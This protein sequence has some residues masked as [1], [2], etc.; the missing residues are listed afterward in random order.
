MTGLGSVSSVAVMVLLV[1]VA[2]R[3]LTTLWD[4]LVLVEIRPAPAFVLG[5]IHR[6]DEPG[7]YEARDL[8]AGVAT[9]LVVALG[10]TFSG[11][12]LLWGFHPGTLGGPGNHLGFRPQPPAW[13]RWRPGGGS[14]RVDPNPV[15]TA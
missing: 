4:L 7:A 12:R 11:H 6:R 14:V 5:T 10:L 15:S 13:F 1:A 8:L 2:L 9:G 3:P